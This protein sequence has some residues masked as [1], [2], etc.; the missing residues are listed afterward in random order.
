MIAV[1]GI[2]PIF[3]ASDTSTLSVKLHGQV[4][5]KPSTDTRKHLA[6]HFGIEPNFPAS[7]TGVLPIDDWAKDTRTLTHD[8]AVLCPFKYTNTRIFVVVYKCN[9]T[10]ST[11][12]TTN[13]SIGTTS[14]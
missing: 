6:A 9:V 8:K 10:P 12:S 1:T 13:T 3:L 14:R 2:E 11:A 7:D 4:H 5:T